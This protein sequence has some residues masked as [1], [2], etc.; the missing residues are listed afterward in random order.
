MLLHVLA[1]AEAVSAERTVVVLGHGS[2]KVTPYLPAGCAVAIQDRQRGTGHALLAAEKELPPGWVLVLPGDTPL[3]TGEVLERLVQAHVT[4]GAVATVLTM[5]LDDPS[6]YGRIVRDESGGVVRIVEHRD[7]E[8][9]ELAIRELNTGV[10]VLPVPLAL[11]V[12][13]TVGSDN[14][15]GEIYLTDVIAGLLARG[16]KV[17]AATVDDARVVLGV[18][19]PVEL[20]E[21]ETIMGHRIKRRWMLEGAT[22]IDPSST[23]IEAG[24]TLSPR[25]IV[26][27][28]TTLGGTTSIGPDCEVGPCSTILDSRVS[29]GCFLP[30]SYIRSASITAGT[31]LAPFA[32]IDGD[33]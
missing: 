12:L 27:P 9:E 5:I 31:R 6:G 18:N 17:G 8:P 15:Q 14:D 30:H 20:A 3:I 28:F 13:R 29:R 19:S 1:A 7:A 22:I 16:E 26:R 25:V 33:A 24:V 2:E 32:A 10:F 23:V 4:S 21:A 11:E